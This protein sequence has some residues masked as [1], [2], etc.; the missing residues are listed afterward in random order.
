MKSNKQI[1]KEE[2]FKAIKELYS[3]YKLPK[4]N[5]SQD[6][7]ETF[8]D[9]TSR[10]FIDEKR[11]MD[12]I[13]AVNVIIRRAIN[14]AMIDN[15]KELTIDYLVRALPDMYVCHVFLD[16]IKKMQDEISESCKHTKEKEF[17]KA[18]IH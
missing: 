10:A 14:F 8:F 16:E 13:I 18:E 11:T 2:M 3:E 17:V 15:T 12:Y 4:M 9:V 7:W 5:I 6:E 1:G